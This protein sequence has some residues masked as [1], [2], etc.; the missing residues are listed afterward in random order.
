MLL[1]CLTI[2]RSLALWQN[3]MIP[4]LRGISYNVGFLGFGVG[5]FVQ[6]MTDQCKKN[7]IFCTFQGVIRNRSHLRVIETETLGN[8]NFKGTNLMR[9]KLLFWF[10]FLLWGR[11]FHSSF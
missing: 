9:Q 6:A 3:T 1:W 4:P 11:T 2:S 5:F 8:A 10:V 7:L